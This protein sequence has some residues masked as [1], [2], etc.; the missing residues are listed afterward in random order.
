[1]KLRLKPLE[2]HFISVFLSSKTIKL[3]FIHISRGSQTLYFWWLFFSILD[4]LWLIVVHSR[5]NCSGSLSDD[6]PLQTI[7]CVLETNFFQ[8]LMINDEA[9]N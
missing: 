6:K 1:M 8:I 7:P 9:W 2:P 5:R 4:R 3:P